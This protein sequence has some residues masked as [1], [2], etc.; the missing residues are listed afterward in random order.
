MGFGWTFTKINP[1]F[2]SI[3]KMYGGIW[4]MISLR[5]LMVYFLLEWTVFNRVLQSAGITFF[6]FYG[7]SFGAWSILYRNNLSNTVTIVICCLNYPHAERV[8]FPCLLRHGSSSSFLTKRFYGSISKKSITIPRSNIS[9][10]NS[11]GSEDN[12]SKQQKACLYISY[13]NC[14]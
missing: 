12:S 1:F 8:L 3:D 11:G 13:A 2:Y 10:S 9:S 4:I 7:F 5:K 6:Y 14:A